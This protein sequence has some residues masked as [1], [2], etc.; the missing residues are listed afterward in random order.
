MNKLLIL[1]RL[2]LCKNINEVKDM[3]LFLGLQVK[4]DIDHPNLL[5]I[6]YSYVNGMHNSIKTNDFTSMYYQCRGV[7]FE[8]DTYNVVCYGMDGMFEFSS[9]VFDDITEFKL[10]FENINMTS[11]EEMIDGF[12]I[13]LFYYGDKWNFATSRCMDASKTKWV[14][15]EKNFYDMFKEALLSNNINIDFDTLDKF[16]CYTFVV[17]HPEN[18]IV[19]KYD[20][21]D[22]YHVA[23]R[24]LTTLCEVD[25][26]IGIKKPKKYCITND[27][28]IDSIHLLNQ[29]NNLNDIDTRC[30][31]TLRIKGYIFKDNNGNRYKIKFDTYKLI[32]D[33]RMIDSNNLFLKYLDLMYDKK[34]DIYLEYFPEMREVFLAKSAQ[35]DK[36]IDIILDYYGKYVEKKYFE[37]P[38]FLTSIMKNIHYN[39]GKKDYVQ[40]MVLKMHPKRIL[41]L[42]NKLYT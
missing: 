27:N 16:C 42:S 35:L 26:D 31:E 40:N 38:L 29:V 12:Q 10:M 11:I 18:R 24:D 20:V 22:I 28:I 19:I 32:H 41:A 33:L 17:C 4:L 21:P 39:K 6:T 5:L 13:K 1:D 3:C 34:M 2:K 36:I 7:I 9:Y 15:S 37:I 25:V 8:K 14:Y 30:I 23:T